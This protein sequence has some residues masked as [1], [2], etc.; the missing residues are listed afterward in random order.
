[1]LR[2]AIAGGNIG[3]SA[4]ISLLR[5]DANADLIGIYERNPD[6]PGA[7]LARKWNLPV[8]SDV[9]SLCSAGPEMVVNVTGD[10]N[11]STEIRS[12]SSNKIEVIE[13]IG[14]RF[15]WEIIE[16]QKR[17]KIEAFKTVEDQKT[18]FGVITELGE[19]E[20][21]SNFLGF[22]LDK[23]LEMTDAPAGS[24]VVREYGK[25]R[26]AAH[27]GLSRRF[28][29]NK[30]W[31]ILPGGLADDIL[32]SK[33]TVVIQDTL[34]VDYTRN[35]PALISEKIRSM[36]A[37]PVLLRDKVA[38]ILYIDDFKPRQFSD[39]Q[40]ASLTLMTGVISLYI[41]RLNLIQK[42][43]RL[44]LKSFH[45]MEGSND[46]V[47][48]SDPAGAIS[49]FNEKALE[50]LG[51]SKQYLQ[52]RSIEVL[53]KGD[54]W[55]RIRDELSIN[56]SV[57]GFEATVTG[58]G[59]REIEMHLNAV[60]LKNSE[61]VPSELIFL[62]KD[63]KDETNLK[64]V[65]AEKTKE[66]EDLRENLEKKVTERTVQLERI[67][68]ELEYAN[69]L[70]GRFIANMSHELR[71]PL[72]SIL[73]FSDVLLDM[74]FGALTEHQERYIKNIHTS[75]KH[76]LE[77]INNVLDIAK[78]EA[79]KYEMVYETFTVDDVI[80]EVINVMKSLAENKFIEIYVSIGE[81]IGVVTADR[82]KLK[83]ILYNLLSNAIKFTPEGGTVR[84]D[85]SHEEAPQPVVPENGGVQLLK[86]SVQ[87]TGIGIGPEDKEKIFDEF[88]QATSTLS[89]KYGGVGLGLA[90]SKKLV[91]LHGGSIT[92][93][94]SLG[95]GSTFSFTIPDASPTNGTHAVE[96]TEAIS[97]NFP[98]MKDE[99]PLILVV[100]DDLSTA[101]LL[102][103]HLTQA[104]YKVAHA[105]NGE[106]ALVKAKSLQPFAVTLDVLLPKKDGWEVLQELKGDQTTSKIPVI[107]HSIVDNKELAFALGAADYLLKPLDREALLS[108]LEEITIARGKRALP[109][110]VLIIE[111]DEQ[112]TN[113]LKESLEPQGF[114]MYT[115]ATG[116][117][118]VELASALRPAVILLDFSLPDMI[119]YDAIKEIK[120]NPSTKDIP[121]F[122][123]T[124]RDISVSDRLALVGKIER[125]VQKYAFD[126]K[127]LVGHIKELEILYPKRAG[128][129][130]EL[131]G[132]FS[133]R[134][135]Q[136]RLA[137]EVE[138]ATRYKLPLN[139]LL[140]DLDD[141][142][143]YAKKHGE[144]YGNM[145]LKKVADLIRKNIRG[146]DIVVRYGGDSFAILLPNTV[147]SAALSMSNRFN[148]IIKNYPFVYEN[149]QPRG[150][151]T[152]SIGLTFLD[153]QT[154]EE[155]VLCAEKALARAFGKGGDRVEVYSREQNEKEEVEQY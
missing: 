18:I 7:I 144:Y 121:V 151:I 72:N 105:F 124:E 97:L 118:G 84:V 44:N 54:Q 34:K 127:E 8:F 58:S 29:E 4:L 65:V 76:L 135:F 91:E 92:L 66:I 150:H 74:T 79:G 129:I 94:S 53:L 93:T 82:I 146:S 90:L 35:N 78:I 133:H 15:I 77:L 23:I 108:K 11:L 110:S 130:D 27:K 89:K 46:A 117:R 26:L 60:L 70:K 5:G 49:S 52:G 71:T 57:K 109:V 1:M 47:V 83:Q 149:S 138:R 45:M 61:G 68:R 154:T 38:G 148:A 132:A 12:V 69:Q 20:G 42:A 87:D 39:R 24:I 96:D 51:Y 86:F 134:Y 3:A 67:N 59:G 25:M 81:G 41:D 50:M 112:V 48:I 141:F 95:E 6:S 125:I 106:E 122:I 100:E 128:L 21:L 102:T 153:G 64:N 14:A 140:L 139:L 9:K 85:V 55:S 120:E 155:F 30:V 56:M 40:Q 137:Q 37:C 142:N 88:E 143:Q 80:S 19:D 16:K 111:S 104:G 63:L 131:T 43:A 62:F 152:A 103:L 113:A 107:I 28:T 31:D 17:A 119:G 73:G 115:A 99:A 136:I 114:L 75:G 22:I 147:I 145:T 13:G 33:Q 98:W 36:I 101:E 126:S 10:A 2:T 32:R 123:L 116:K